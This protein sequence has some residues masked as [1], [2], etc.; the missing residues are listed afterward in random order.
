MPQARANGL[1]IEYES[2][3]PSDGAPLLLIHGVG[4]QLIRWPD[5][6]CDKFVRAGFHVI[7]MDNR[8]I[9]LSAH[10]DHAGLPDLAA[11]TAAQARGE[12]AE[13]PYTLADMAADSIGL[14]DALGIAS[15]H[16][17]GVSLGGM[18]AQVMAIEHGPRIRSLTVMMSQ[19]GNPLVS[20]V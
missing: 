3:G 9:G 1:T 20:L 18:I 15:A 5:A 11:V 7:R 14:L 10:M 8:D 17:L 12:A 6:L 16:V 2:C 19:A 4:A 13:L